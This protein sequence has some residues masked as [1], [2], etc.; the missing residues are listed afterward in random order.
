MED[1]DLKNHLS[2]IQRKLLKVSF[3]NV[4]QFNDVKREIGPIL[5]RNR[6]KAKVS[7]NP[8]THTL[9]PSAHLILPL[10]C[11]SHFIPTDYCSLYRPPP[12]PLLLQRSI[13]SDPGHSRMHRRREGARRAL[14][15][16]IPHRH[17]HQM[18]PLVHRDEEGRSHEYGEEGGSAA[19]GRAS[20][21]RLG[22]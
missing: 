22:Y 3:W 14:P 17:R 15:R 21:L 20:C 6:A 10:S 11:H 1:L 5:S 18:R 16:P 8:N 19:E 4:N 12:R 9:I 7:L 2:G 13:Q